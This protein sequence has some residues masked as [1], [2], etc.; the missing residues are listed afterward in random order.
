MPQEV[1]LQSDLGALS[2]QGLGAFT[3]ILAILSADD[4][5]PVALLQIEKLGSAFPTSGP[6]AEKVKGLLQRCSSVRLDRL[7]MVMGW[8]KNDTA[9]LMG[10]S[11]GGQAASLLCLCLVNFFK[12]EDAGLTLS[13]LSSTM[14]PRGSN[15]AGVSQLAEVAK[16]LSGKLSTLG[17]G[18]HLAREVKRMLDSYEAMGKKAPSNLLEQFSIESMVEILQLSSRALMDDQRLCRITG[19]QSIGLIGGLLQILFHKD[20][21]ISIEGVEMQTATNAKILLEISSEGP[22]TAYLEAQR[23]TLKGGILPIGTCELSGNYHG[24][25]RFEYNW[26]GWLADNLTLTF[27]NWGYTCNQSIFDAC[28]QLVLRLAPHY[29]VSST[30]K[31]HLGLPQGSSN[32]QSLSVLLGNRLVARLQTSCKTVLRSSHTEDRTLQEAFDHLQKLVNTQLVAESCSCFHNT[33]RSWI[34]SSS[35]DHKHN[36]SCVRLQLWSAISSTVTT[37]IIC[38]FINTDQ[39]SVAS[40][41]QLHKLGTLSDMGA[42]ILRREEKG[43]ICVEEYWDYIVNII[44]PDWLLDKKRGD[45]LATSSACC[46]VFP[47]VL[48]NFCVPQRQEVT[49]DCVEGR[50]IFDNRYH[51][52]LDAKRVRLRE[53]KK[54]YPSRVPLEPTGLGKHNEEPLVTI[55]EGFNFLELSCSI[56]YQ[57][58]NTQLDARS[59]TT[60][61]LGMYWSDKCGHSSSRPLPSGHD[62]YVETNIANPAVSGAVGIVMTRWNPVAQFLACENGYQAVLIRDSCLSC[63]TDSF[64]RTGPTVFIVG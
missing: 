47:S 60:G 58:V 64:T 32:S 57:G 50:L 49:F 56:K 31:S 39:N 55:R 41:S 23:K 10:E 6:C 22:T 9:S 28:H 51:N 43:A 21:S 14:L 42:K 18:N 35:F 34:D 2:L 46:T 13:Q 27:S 26:N 24:I 8:R 45:L 40:P 11:A 48:R 59:V 20:L 62:M 5:A 3:S 53:R 61:Y 52:R 25:S 44:A 36:R 4:V 7:S 15:L 1:Q 17:F 54:L 16:L 30:F 29:L 12:H 63:A 19:S 38:A 37:A 33:C